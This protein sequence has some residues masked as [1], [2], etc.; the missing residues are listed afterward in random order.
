MSRRDVLAEN[1]AMLEAQLQETVNHY[2]RL[3]VT[4]I[5]LD[6]GHARLENKKIRLLNIEKLLYLSR[7]KGHAHADFLTILMQIELQ[8]LNEIIEFATDARYYLDTN[9]TLSSK[10]CVSKCIKIKKKKKKV[11]DNFNDDKKCFH[12]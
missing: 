4:K 2:G 5:L 6:D 3:T 12:F 9:Y 1:I 8:K 11:K 7:D 10:R